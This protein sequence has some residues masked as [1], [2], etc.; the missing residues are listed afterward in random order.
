MNELLHKLGTI[1]DVYPDF[2]IG[3]LVY[4]KKKKNRL[5]IMLDYLNYNFPNQ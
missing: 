2:V 5:D 1:S 3:V 4:V